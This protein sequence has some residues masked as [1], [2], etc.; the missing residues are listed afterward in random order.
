M[1]HGTRG[2]AEPP[3]CP[4]GGDGQEDAVDLAAGVPWCGAGGQPQPR[5]TAASPAAAGGGSQGA[6]RA[7]AADSRPL[8]PGHPADA[9]SG[10][11]RLTEWEALLRPRGS[12]H[13]HGAPHAATGP[14]DHKVPGMPW[15]SLFTKVPPPTPG[16][17]V[18]GS[19]VQGLTFCKSSSFWC[20]LEFGAR[21]QSAE[22]PAR[23]RTST[24][25]PR[26]PELP[27]GASHL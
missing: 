26:A 8:E 11:P 27:A 7:S 16:V 6:S 14:P 21:W 9:H 24:C 17:G 5:T 20:S 18:P 22:P 15:G 13:S 23:A 1:T 19:G 12:L 4:L 10:R 2:R 3:A 25:G